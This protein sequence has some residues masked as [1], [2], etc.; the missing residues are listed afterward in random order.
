MTYLELVN[1]LKTE[2]L[3]SPFIERVENDDVPEIDLDKTTIY[4]MAAFYLENISL[5]GR[6]N[7]YNIPLLVADILDVNKETDQDNRDFIWNQSILVISR[8]VEKL[9]RGELSQTPIEIGDV[10]LTPF[11]DRLD[12]GLAGM[13]TVLSITVVNDMTIC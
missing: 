1:I 8:L 6:I 9:R 4:P 2:L 7:T 5:P 12:K 13:E 10:S 11:T 3:S